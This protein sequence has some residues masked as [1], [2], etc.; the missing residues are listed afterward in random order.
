ML[1]FDDPWRLAIAGKKCTT[2]K[3]DAE[4]RQFTLIVSRVFSNNF[5]GGNYW[6][7]E[8]WIG[9]S[10]VL[11]ALKSPKLMSFLNVEVPRLMP[12]ELY[13]IVI[14]TIRSNII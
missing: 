14:Y 2:I 4:Y 13:Y 1:N 8:P 9:P 7:F 12:D 6:I 10:K 11:M 5:L 3:I